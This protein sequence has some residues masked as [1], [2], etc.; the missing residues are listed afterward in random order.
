VQASNNE[1]FLL[2][3]PKEEPTVKYEEPKMELPFVSDEEKSLIFDKWSGYHQ[4]SASDMLDTFGLEG[5]HIPYWVKKTF[6]EGIH[7]GELT[8]DEF[9]MA[10]EYLSK[11]EILT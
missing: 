8:I 9:T 2:V 10:L 5:D 1:S 3:E 7:K 4:E 6:G 11:N